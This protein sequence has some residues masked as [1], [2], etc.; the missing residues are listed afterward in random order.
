MADAAIDK[1]KLPRSLIV[2][3]ALLAALGYLLPSLV[4]VGFRGAYAFAAAVAA[5]TVISVVWVAVLIF[6]FKHHGRVAAW[7]LLECPFALNGPLT[8]LL[9]WLISEFGHDT[10]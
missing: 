6:A 3:S 9:L 2:R 5:G 10:L 4:Q 8:F 7:L 1:R